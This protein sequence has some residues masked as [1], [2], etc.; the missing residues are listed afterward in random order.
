MTSF[1]CPECGAI[2]IKSHLYVSTVPDLD[3]PW[4]NVLQQLECA[5]CNFY[6]PAHLGERWDN[7]SYEDAKKEWIKI[8]KR[9]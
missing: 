2:K 4:S 8:Y 6:I 1:Q 9:K 5:S 3:D 7:I